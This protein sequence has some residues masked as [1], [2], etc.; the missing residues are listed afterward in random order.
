MTHCWIQYIDAPAGRNRILDGAVGP[1]ILDGLTPH[2]GTVAMAR[3]NVL[4]FD[5]RFLAAED[6]EWWLRMA[7]CTPINTIP[8]IGYLLRRHGQPRHRIDMATRVRSRLLLLEVHRAY[9]A[10]HPQ[11]AAFQ[12]KR[13]GLLA[14]ASGDVALARAAFAR[15]FR[16]RPQIQ[17]LWHL[18]GSVP[19]TARRGT[20]PESRTSAS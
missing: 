18:L 2:L 19:R 16:L 12:W 17:T 11:A 4:P 5:E 13:V 9:F 20:A 6:V 8:R 15:S 7:Q 3:E 1:R 14:G 10:A